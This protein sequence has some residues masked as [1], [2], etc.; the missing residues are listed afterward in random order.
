MSDQ[1]LT[2]EQDKEDYSQHYNCF[3]RYMEYTEEWAQ[4]MHCSSRCERRHECF[5]E[6]EARKL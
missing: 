5:R 4:K 2:Y 3:G 6:K 1:S